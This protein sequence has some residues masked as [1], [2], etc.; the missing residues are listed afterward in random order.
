MVFN[1]SCQHSY[2]R[3]RK[4]ELTL[5]PPWLV[6]SLRSFL[7]TSFHDKT[8]P[9]SVDKEPNYARL[10]RISGYDH[11]G[12]TQLGKRTEKMVRVLLYQNR[13][14]TNIFSDDALRRGQWFWET[15]EHE[16]LNI[17]MSLRLKNV[18]KSLK[19]CFMYIISH[20]ELRLTKRLNS[21]VPIV[22][23][24]RL[25]IKHGIKIIESFQ[26]L[27]LNPLNT[28]MVNYLRAK[29]YPKVQYKEDT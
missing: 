8:R 25:K 14:I 26:I 27:E 28:K 16:L 6:S 1:E 23:R 24:V 15:T 9:D 19:C 4:T 13:Q 5:I 2:L 12:I 10:E 7:H 20:T 17:W 21:G 11:I 29:T 22:P 18:P 3:S